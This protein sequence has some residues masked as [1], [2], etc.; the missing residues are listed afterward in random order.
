[1]FQYGYETLSDFA[2]TIE[3]YVTFNIE[4]SSAQPVNGVYN[5]N[6]VYTKEIYQ[7]DTNTPIITEDN[8]PFTSV[9]FN[10]VISN[11]ITSPLILYRH[12]YG[13]VTT[14]Y[15]TI[16]KHLT[17]TINLDKNNFSWTKV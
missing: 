13:Q 4:K 11:S 5:Y 16:G 9:T 12:G 14:F 3:P 6:I 10:I 8:L 17:Y 2:I 7:Y 1:M 15:D